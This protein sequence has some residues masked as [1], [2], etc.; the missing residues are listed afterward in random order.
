MSETEDDESTEQSEAEEQSELESLA[1]KLAALSNGETPNI[2]EGPPSPFEAADVDWL[3]N[4]WIARVG[5]V[6][7]WLSLEAPLN[8]S[9]GAPAVCEALFTM[10][11]DPS[12]SRC[13]EVVA[14]H[15]RLT[16][17]GIAR[18]AARLDT[19][20]ELKDAFTED[21]ENEKSLAE[22]SRAW[23]EGWEEAS[24]NS[25]D[26]ARATVHAKVETFQ[27]YKFC[28]FAKSNG[29]EL[30][31]SYQR[32]NVWTDKE[33]AELIDSVLRG[34]PLPSII[35]NRRNNSEVLEIV[36]G[37]QRLTAILRF[38][39][40]HPDAIRFVKAVEEEDA[41]PAA[42]FDESYKKW[43][44][45]VQR[46]R[47]L[48]SE[49]EKK[50]FLPFRYRVPK[51]AG[52]GGGLEAL[53]GKYYSEAKD[54]SVQIED[55]KEPIRRIFE[56]IGSNYKLSVILYED[57]DVRQI[58]KVFGLYNRQGKKLNATEVRNAIYHHLDIARLMLLLAGDSADLNALAPYLDVSE[59][60]LRTI[61][62]LLTS[63]VVSEGR[64][65]RTKVTSWV[66]ALLV[67]PI[68]NRGTTPPCPGST[69]LIEKMMLG[70]ADNKNH[71]MRSGQSCAQLA[72]HLR[73]GAVLF[74][75]LRNMDAFWPQFTHPTSPGEK[76]EDLPAVAVWTACSIAAMSG[77]AAT[78]DTRAAVFE[79]TR[80]TERLKKQQAR[81]QWG[82]I[83][84]VTL[85]LLKA[86]KVDASI[87]TI[88]T[89]NVGNDCTA[90]LE[91]RLD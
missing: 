51:G 6:Q 61:P 87:S 25:Y 38:V 64:F 57:T 88:L 70:V 86:M 4:A 15:A 84:R 59:F 52:D 77:V 83:A 78:Q 13:F 21:L 19:A 54:F 69:S 30:N 34:I 1:E 16:D 48:S 39:G 71:M 55:K 90:A 8:T 5:E 80:N 10:L 62:D 49:D 27:I 47:G 20:T 66:S 91:A 67:H 76:W 40:R 33:S 68:E 85:N 3:T 89:R 12:P 29:L 14:G 9:D 73:D 7:A 31:P 23:S 28:D 22:A 50:Y 11:Q 45:K 56:G 79:V 72:Q 2:I 63:L 18:L 36:D 58:Q 46:K 65:N 75:A 81:S 74:T 37:K 60:D 44:K 17:A 41:V 82:Y 32:G 42:L 35:L 53:N 26:T 24:P 43:R